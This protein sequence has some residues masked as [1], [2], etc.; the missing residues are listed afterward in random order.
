MGLARAAGQDPAFQPDRAALHETVWGQTLDRLA[1]NAVRLDQA[2]IS[3]DGRVAPGPGTRAALL[4]SSWSH[5]MATHPGATV[6]DWSAIMPH[7]SPAFRPSLRGPPGRS[8]PVLLDPR[9]AAPLQ[10]DAVSQTA[11]LA[12]Q[13]QEGAWLGLSVGN[14]P[15]ADT[16]LAVLTGCV[17][18]TGLSLCSSWYDR[19]RAPTR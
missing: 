19:T 5:A 13:D 11:W 3:L 10:F 9:A 15:R 6:T 7:V 8:Q 2:R 1:R 16:H 4:D 18:L 17:R 12:V 14:G